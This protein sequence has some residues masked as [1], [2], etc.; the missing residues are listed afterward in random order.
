M[1]SLSVM[2]NKGVWGEG[3]GQG[4]TLSGL[5]SGDEDG[6]TNKQFTLRRMLLFLR[7]VLA[8]PNFE[9]GGILICIPRTSHL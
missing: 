7:H 6:Q 5:L 3:G 8:V 1:F 9:K 2:L 4:E